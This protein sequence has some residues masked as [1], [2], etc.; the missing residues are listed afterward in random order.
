MIIKAQKPL[1]LLSINL[2]DS[3]FLPGLHDIVSIAFFQS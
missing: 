2:P 1:Q 3:N